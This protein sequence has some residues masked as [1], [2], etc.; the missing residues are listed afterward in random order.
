MNLIGITFDYMSRNRSH[1]MDIW[2]VYVCMSI[3]MKRVA[4]DHLQGPR[5]SREI[6]KRTET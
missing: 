6:S 1:L 5:N 3:P 4:R 2:S